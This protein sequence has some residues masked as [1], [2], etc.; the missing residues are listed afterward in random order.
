MT[1]YYKIYGQKLV[2]DFAFPQ[3]VPAGETEE[4]TSEIYIREGVFPEELKRPRFTFRL[5]T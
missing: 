4:E 5:P 2:S 3:L 1:Y